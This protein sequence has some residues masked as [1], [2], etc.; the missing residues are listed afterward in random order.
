MI[1]ITVST[2]IFQL[3]ISYNNSE[4]NQT[5]MNRMI[6]RVTATEFPPLNVIYI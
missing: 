1:N 2:R 5:L 4:A 3:S 6:I